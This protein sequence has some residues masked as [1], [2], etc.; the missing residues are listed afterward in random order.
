MHNKEMREK[1]SN[2]LGV[3]YVVVDR[4]FV[5]QSGVAF[6]FQEV[7]ENTPENIKRI[8]KE[9]LS[10]GDIYDY[11][12]AK[13]TGFLRRKKGYFK[14][15]EVNETGNKN[16]VV[17]V[18][19]FGSLIFFLVAALITVGV[20]AIYMSFQYTSQYLQEY[21][22]KYSA[23]I[24]SFTMAVFATSAFEV[25]LIL[26]QHH[27]VRAMPIILLAL[28]FCVTVFSM[29]STMA[30]NYNGYRTMKQQSLEA[31]SEENS[32][33]LL[34]PVI[35]E[36]INTVAR[37]IDVMEQS[38]NNYIETEGYSEWRA[39]VMRKELEGLVS[40]RDTLVVEKKEILSKTPEAAIVEDT[41]ERTYFDSVAEITNMKP[42]TFSFILNAFPAI[43]IDMIAPFSFAAALMLLGN[44]KKKGVHN[45]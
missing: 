4:H 41:T 36:Q 9:R 21:L 43:F 29:N 16:S 27:K 20:G 8:Y 25:A 10:S 37:Q 32:G 15:T 1:V 34:L 24:L 22:D 12:Y 18:F 5:T 44:K 23:M 39:S 35:D 17:N 14:D 42:E 11:T 45:A 28:W 40:K 30:I 26:W 33:R 19:G 13:T 38:I 31:K 2:I 7:E 3:R 6:S